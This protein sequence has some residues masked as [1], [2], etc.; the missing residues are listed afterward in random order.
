ASMG[1]LVVIGSRERI[2]GDS[3]NLTPMTIA[4]IATSTTI[5][6]RGATKLNATAIAPPAA[7]PR[8][9]PKLFAVAIFAIALVRVVIE[10]ISAMYAAAAGGVAAITVDCRMRVTIRALRSAPPA[11]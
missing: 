11:R 5:I 2:Y 6:K 4:I 7:G 3:L 10:E 8:I 1:V 9:L